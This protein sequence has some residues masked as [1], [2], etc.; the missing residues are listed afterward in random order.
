MPT[1]ELELN[2]IGNKENIVKGV[3][4]KYKTMLSDKQEF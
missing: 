1:T 3:K 2:I 4:N